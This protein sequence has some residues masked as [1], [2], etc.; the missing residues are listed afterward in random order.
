MKNRLPFG[1]AT[2]TF[3]TGKMKDGELDRTNIL[4]KDNPR[5]KT[6]HVSYNPPMSTN[7]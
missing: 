4:I 6:D 1:T 5:N 3:T 7:P 2:H